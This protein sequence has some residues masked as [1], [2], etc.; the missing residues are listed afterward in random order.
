MTADDPALQALWLP[1]LDGALDW[2][3]DGALFLGARDGWPLRQ[4]DWPGL[5]CVQ[6]FKPAFDALQR[7]GFDVASTPDA[8]RRWPLV[9]LLP[10]RQREA[11]RALFAQALSLVAPGGRIVAAVPNAEGAKSG[12]VDL[13]RLTGPVQSLS[14]HKCRV[15]WTEPSPAS[16]ESTLAGEW[17]EAGAPRALALDVRGHAV[18]SRPGVF[19]WDRIDRASALLAAHLPGDLSGEGADLGAGWGYLS[20]EILSRC[21][22]VRAL[23]LYEADA[24]ALELARINLAPFAA[25]TRIAFHWADVTAGLPR[26]YDFIVTNPP[27]H[28]LGQANRPDV[29]RA[30]LAVAADA[31]KPG[32]RLWLVANRHLPYESVLD[33]RFANVR[34]VAQ[35]E[36]FKVVEAMKA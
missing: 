1:F 23:D 9:L 17:R 25:R 31:L 32:G 13:A 33:A 3:R 5:A 21:P 28:A 8:D 11:A 4:R 29:G 14:K 10:P 12:E 35:A 36:G 2:P 27:F 6:P 30:F 24:D 15:F 7:S 19:A 16:P 20:M 26:T 34:M 18:R 22:G